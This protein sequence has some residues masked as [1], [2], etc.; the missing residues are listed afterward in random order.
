LIY[1]SLNA[2]DL[3]TAVKSLAIQNYSAN[4]KNRHLS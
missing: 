1:V 3:I 4:L 2:L